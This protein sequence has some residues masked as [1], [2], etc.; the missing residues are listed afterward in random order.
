MGLGLLWQTGCAV[1]LIGGGA[2]AGIGG[3]AYVKGELKSS[4]G[5]S[6]DK[7][8]AATLGA[9]EELKFP[10]TTQNKDALSAQLVAHTAKNKKIH[11]NLKAL[12]DN[13]AEIKIRVGTFGDE[14]LSLVIMD[15]IKKKL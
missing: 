5:V 11:V 7:A 6:L 8:W 14:A 3:F 2:A 9:M 15:R 10:V 4:E 1:L 13:S 12:S